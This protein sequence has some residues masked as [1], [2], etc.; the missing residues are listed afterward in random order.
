MMELYV[1]DIVASGEAGILAHAAAVYDAPVPENL[2]RS[3]GASRPPRNPLRTFLLRAGAILG[4]LSLLAFA[5][6]RID[7]SHDLSRLRVTV[8]SGEAQGHYH[9]VVEQMARLAGERRGTVTELASAGSVE[10]VK[11]LT[12]AARTCE[13]EFALVQ[14]GTDWTAGVPGG[15]TPLQVYGRFARR[16][17]VLFLGKNADALRDFAQLKGLRVGV[18]A[19]GSGTEQ[20][21]RQIFGLPDF[22]ALGAQL[23]THPTDEQL[24]LLASGGLDLG[25]FVIQDDAP[26]VVDAIRDRGL[27][28]ASFAHTSGVARRLQ[29][30]RT[31]HIDAG[32]YDA[33]RGLPA[34]DKDVMRVETLLVGNGCA[35]RTQAVDLLTV[36]AAE[37]PD[38]I[39]HN[40]ETE[41]T[42]SLPTAAVAKEF[43]DAGGPQ[44]ADLYVPWLVDVMP[45]ANWAYVV[46]GVSILFNA[47]GAANRFRLWRIDASRVHI[48]DDVVRVFGKGVTLG[49][50][51]KLAPASD[52]RFADPAV[53][54]EVRRAVADYEELHARSRRQSLSVLVPMGQEMSYRY[55]EGVIQDALAVLRGFLRRAEGTG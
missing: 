3:L 27:E 5:V 50:I 39:R 16:E 13:A 38:F 25:V 31:G 6:S 8:L 14:D 55:Q 35:G 17:A 1:W 42:T 46:M 7:L 22:A 18:G 9:T 28:I 32:I 23:S 12:A 29:Y 52:A 45:P 34:T 40:K 48:E 4:G 51:E 36:V 10:N 20:I 43:F 37:F 54:G 30:L 44:A 47:M 19:T 24:A 33:I 26:V 21:A 2:H 15:K 11:R 53:L 41:N 49:D